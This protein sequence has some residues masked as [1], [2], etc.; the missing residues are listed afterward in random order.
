MRNP[1]LGKHFG[2]RP[3]FDSHELCISNTISCLLST[4][5]CEILAV[6]PH[7]HHL[8]SSFP[9]PRDGGLC[10]S[11][12]ISQLWL[13]KCCVITTPNTLPFY[14]SIYFSSLWLCWVQACATCLPT[15]WHQSGQ[16]GM[17][18]LRVRNAALC[19]DPHSSCQINHTA[20][21]NVTGTG[22]TVESP[23][24]RP[25]SLTGREEAGAV[26]PSTPEPTTHL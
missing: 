16:T 11:L 7:V 12:C 18:L 6:S 8:L 15:F 14:D 21:S 9:L 5:W 19:C 1:E 13:Q 2:K 4:S 25:A 22:D 20:K 3:C 23:G 17:P 10:L 24:K 26:I